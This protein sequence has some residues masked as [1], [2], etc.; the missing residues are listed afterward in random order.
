MSISIDQL[1]ATFNKEGQLPNPKPAIDIIAP[2]YFAAPEPSA[3]ENPDGWAWVELAKLN[4]QRN[5][6]IIMLL[7]IYKRHVDAVAAREL[8]DPAMNWNRQM[9]AAALFAKQQDRVVASPTYSDETWDGMISTIP[10]VEFHIGEIRSAI[11]ECGSAY[12]MLEV[13][14]VG[15]PRLR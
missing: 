3:V 8:G 12:G 11:R 13:P 7:M 6:E 9:V 15:P 5:C 4:H 1:I 14:D 10:D 2:R